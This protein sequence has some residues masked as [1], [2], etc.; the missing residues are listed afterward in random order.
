MQVLVIIIVAVVVVVIVVIIVIIIAVIVIGSMTITTAVILGVI[1]IVNPLPRIPNSSVL[2][3]LKSKNEK[4]L[5]KNTISN[6]LSHHCTDA[7]VTR[8]ERPKDVIKQAR[9]AAAKN[10]G[11]GGPLDF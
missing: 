10:S 2:C 8:P 7:W 5:K 11:P 3:P 1:V 9:R 6:A 4:I